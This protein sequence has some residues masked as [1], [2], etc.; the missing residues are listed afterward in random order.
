M[1]RFLSR[2]PMLL[3]AFICFSLC[4]KVQSQDF[5]GKTVTAIQYEPVAQPM[6]PRDLARMQLVQVG[7][8]LNP[9]QVA[10][11]LDRLFST[12][13]YDDLQ[14]DAREA[15]NDVVVTFIT[16]ARRF[17]GHVGAQGHISDPP[18]RAII[19]SGAQMNLGT[20]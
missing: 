19:I 12:G 9:R 10:A 6:D 7:E 8:P 11:T 1:T 20:P 17:I 14:V 15:G 16:R 2:S 18:S 3:G 5:T 13:L 4:G